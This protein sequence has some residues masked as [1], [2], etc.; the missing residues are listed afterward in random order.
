MNQV[1]MR[2]EFQLKLIE[3]DERYLHRSRFVRI[4]KIIKRHHVMI[5][6]HIIISTERENKC[7]WML[8]LK[9]K[10]NWLKKNYLNNHFV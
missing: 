2:H 10:S 6:F 8:L 4:H 3:A 9:F 5:L 7:W 1:M